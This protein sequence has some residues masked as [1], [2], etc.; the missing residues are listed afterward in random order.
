MPLFF[1]I[2]F[3]MSSITASKYSFRG[4][5]FVIPLVS[6]DGKTVDILNMK[7]E[8]VSLPKE[9][10]DKL[11]S[12]ATENELK[13]AEFLYKKMNELE[14]LSKMSEEEKIHYRKEKDLEE[15]FKENEAFFDLVANGFIPEEIFFERIRDFG[16]EAGLIGPDMEFYIQK[17]KE[18]IE[19]LRYR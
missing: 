4:E 6:Q 11:F 5:M 12:P 14:A 19:E 1:V 15:I 8:L 9:S 3:V 17:S 7:G 16:K 18:K 13:T 10:F 2:F